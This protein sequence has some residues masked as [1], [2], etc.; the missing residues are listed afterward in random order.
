[1]EKLKAFMVKAEAWVEEHPRMTFIFGSAAVLVASVLG[2][3][4]G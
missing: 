1:M 4:L 2:A 3:V